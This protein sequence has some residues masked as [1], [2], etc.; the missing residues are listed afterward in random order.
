MVGGGVVGEE[1]GGVFVAVGL[2][3]LD[4]VI[5]LEGLGGVP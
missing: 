1:G 5:R 3:V 2:L 4:Q